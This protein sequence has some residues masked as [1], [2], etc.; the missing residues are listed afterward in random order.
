[1]AYLRTD[2][3][4]E[5]PQPYST[6][7][8]EVVVCTARDELADI[9]P[10]ILSMG[11]LSAAEVER[12]FCRG[13]AVAL[14]CSSGE[15][16]GYMW[17]GFCSGIELGFDTCWIIRN[18]EALRYGSFVIPAFRGHGVH[19]VVNCALNNYALERGVT[20]TLGSVSA[21]NRQSL[22]LAKHY[23]RASAMTVLLVRFRLRSFT[24][25]TSWRAPL[26]S[27]FLWAGRAERSASPRESALG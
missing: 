13:D 19:S 27:R 5:V 7:K 1:V 4:R 22:S 16:V 15:P 17:M 21:L 14:A 24:M 8:F 26:A 9:K 18:G 12:R 3:T 23:H 2:L 6:A 11:E 25:R 20:R 10:R